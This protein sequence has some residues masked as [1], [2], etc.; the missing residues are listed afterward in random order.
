MLEVVDVDD[1]LILDPRVLRAVRRYRRRRLLLSVV[2]RVLALLPA[3]AY[4]IAWPPFTSQD[5]V[6]QCALPAAALFGGAACLG[7]STDRAVWALDRAP[8]APATARLA[9]HAVALHDLP[10]DADV[11]EAIRLLAVL[12]FTAGRIARGPEDTI[13]RLAADE[14]A[15][16][17]AVGAESAYLGVVDAVSQV[18]D[19]LR[20]AQHV[21]AGTAA[22]EVRDVLDPVESSKRAVAVLNSASRSALALV[23]LATTPPPNG[24]RGTK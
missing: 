5:L 3:L 22:D 7:L 16:I 6:H 1:P 21:V 10:A 23:A 14:L 17:A 18:L 12:A 19:T 13:P 11:M 20:H 24:R 2:A 9:S 8:L 15:T 4:A